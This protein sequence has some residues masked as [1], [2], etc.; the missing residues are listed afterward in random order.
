MTDKQVLS[1]EQQDELL[2][3]LKARFDKNM[4]RHP[5][6][7]WADVQSKLESNPDK[8]ASLY[9]M[10]QTE[11]EPD[12]IGYDEATGQYIFV[13]CSPES[14][15][16]RRSICY[17]R[18]ALEARKLHKPLTSAMDMANEMGIEILTEQQYRELQQLGNFDKKTS[19]WLT[20]PDEIRKLGG[21]IFGDYRYGQVFIYHNGADSYYGARGFRGILKV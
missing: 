21:A 6:I 2:T 18:A 14:P 17:D 10:E 9:A 8:L 4:S 3:L 12:V 7:T 19:S 13:D 11:G 20:T 15:K 16:G 1:M 5:E